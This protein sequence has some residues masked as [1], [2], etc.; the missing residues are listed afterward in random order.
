MLIRKSELSFAHFVTK[1]IK[2]L[3]SP[4][5]YVVYQ[6]AKATMLILTKQE[7]IMLCPT[8]FKFC[9]VLQLSS[10]IGQTIP[11]EGT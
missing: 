8:L 1:I 3:L 5:R 11:S 6:G 10:Q 4:L 9:K 2:H 7:V